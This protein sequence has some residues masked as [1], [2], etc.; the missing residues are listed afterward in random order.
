VLVGRSAPTPEVA[1][2][3]DDLRSLG[4][5]VEAAQCDVA[6]AA[7]LRLTLDRLRPGLPP[8]RGV[9]HAAGLLSDATIANLTARQLDD[10]L[11]PKAAGVRSLEAAVAEDPLDFFVLF[12]SAAALVG[13][14]GQAAYAAANAYLDAFAEARGLPALSVQWGPF[15]DIGLAADD[16]RRGARLEERGMGGIAAHEAWPALVRMLAG[17]TPV[18]G[19]V[20]I[21]LRRWF[22]AYPDTAA[23]GSW[24][25]LLA[26]A[27]S[28]TA[29][30][31]AGSGGEFRSLLL[32]SPGE[33]RTALAEEKVREL[34]GRVLSLDPERVERETP[35][36]ALGLDSLMSL[37]LRNRLE[38]AFAIKLSP[39][40]LWAYGNPKALAGALCEQLAA[41]PT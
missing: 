34:A 37:E 19:Y 28:E 3:L 4:A 8:L 23:L 6:D 1:R 5:R 33:S 35:F 31:G 27:G 25:R 12:S 11:R 26:A 10:V 18:T 17:G 13:N 38:S 40:L 14:V 30:T 21:E 24:Q 7:A 39:T 36:K 22:D 2:R 29:G 41:M 20:P 15:A 9:V 32:A 16:E